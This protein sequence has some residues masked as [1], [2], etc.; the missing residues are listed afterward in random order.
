MTSKFKLFFWL[1]LSFVS[2]VSFFVSVGIFSDTPF[3][4]LSL[5]FL[6][7][8]VLLF[9]GIFLG[10]SFL[11]RVLLMVSIVGV[12]LGFSLLLF[13]VLSLWF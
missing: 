8:A 7:F 4:D 1:C 6:F 5:L 13:G 2:V 10:V 11:L 9:V 3:Y 12:L